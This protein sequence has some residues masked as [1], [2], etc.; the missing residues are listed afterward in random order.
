MKD[1]FDSAFA[2]VVSVEGGYVNHS[3]DPGG[4]TKYGISQRAYPAENIEALTLDRAR[5]IYRKDYWNKICGDDLPD[6]LS[7]LVFD[8]AVNHGISPAA[9]MLQA[10]LKIRADGVM[11]PETLKA[12]KASS[13][14]VCAVFM[15]KR[16]L[17]YTQT[18]NFAT[19]GEGWFKRLFVLSMGGYLS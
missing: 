4:A 12:A 14:S 3:A 5:E 10:A 11:G 2:K 7:H 19:F 1:S 18:Q 9:Q 13:S 17:R 6:P 15:A 8:A 16:A